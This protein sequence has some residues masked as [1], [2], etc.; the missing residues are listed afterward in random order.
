MPGPDR[1]VA[2][3]MEWRQFVMDLGSLQPDLVEAIF[4]RNGALAIT[5]S[6]AGDEPVLEPA[7]GETPLWGATR[8]TGLFSAD[9][10]L[11]AL[12]DDLLHD[13]CIESL[14]A[15]HVEKLAD[16]PWEREWIKDFG[17]MR[18]GKRLWVCPREL[19]IDEAD[20]VVISLDPGLAFGTGTHATTALCLEWLDGLD[21]AGKS[22]LDYGCGSGILAIAALR[23]GALSA[24]AL[25]IDPQAIVAARQNAD[26]NG[27][28]E[29]LT[30]MQDAES[31]ENSYDVVLANILAGTLA[32]HAQTISE[33]VS[34]G[35]CLALSGILEG[36]IDEV[37][38]AY[39][40]WVSFG[41]ATLNDGWVRLTGTKELS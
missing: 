7:P 2:T 34:P 1:L 17:P 20:G 18:F 31:V 28:A 39:S 33:R 8:I 37:L 14:P 25:D 12:R 40:P 27:V 13:F 9:A 21:L 5:L 38:T 3:I 16:R 6:D 35:G 23:L 10:D 30:T 32:E 26:V 22:V 29:K 41:P 36:Q 15:H 11:V 24:M 19:E 4:A